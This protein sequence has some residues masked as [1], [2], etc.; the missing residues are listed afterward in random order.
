[1]TLLAHI[2]RYLCAAIQCRYEATRRALT[3]A[4]S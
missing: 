1:M 3:E 4:D 2:W